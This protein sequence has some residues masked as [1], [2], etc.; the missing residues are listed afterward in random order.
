MAVE[1]RPYVEDIGTEIELDM[2]EDVSAATGITFEVLKPD[3]SEVTWTGITISGTTKF[4]HVVVLGDF[5]KPGYYAIQPKFTLGAWTGR[6][7]TVKIR[8]Y[9]RFS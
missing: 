3:Q 9:P 6:G 1:K 4:K 7:R 5:D 2:D 8:V